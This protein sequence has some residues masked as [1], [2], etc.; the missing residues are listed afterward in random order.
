[1]RTVYINI[2]PVICLI[3]AVSVGNTA[4]MAFFD[5]DMIRYDTSSAETRA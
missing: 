3:K 5:T 4:F 1:M 2:I